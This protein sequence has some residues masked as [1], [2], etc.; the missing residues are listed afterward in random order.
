VDVLEPLSEEELA[1]LGRRNPD[2]RLQ[3]G[4]VFSTPGEH[5][6]KFFILKE[7]KVR[8]FR[9]DPEGHQQTLAQIGDGTPLSGQRLRGSYAEAVEPSVLM[10]LRFEDVQ[11][12]NE[13]NPEV[14]MRLIRLLVERLGRC[15]EK[16]TNVALKAVPAR[17]ASLILDLVEDEGVVTPEGF[18]I[19]AY[20]THEQLGMMI[21]ARR[22]AVSRAFS[23]LREAGAIETKPRRIHVKDK[24]ALERI[25]REERG[26]AGRTS[27]S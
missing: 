18:R 20:Y 25:A 15:D 27:A 7:G 1:E 26:R 10:S 2:I 24:E 8:I 12:L 19:P 22:V 13:R 3:A 21:G 17:L 4:E 14:G 23:K 5:D 9:Q 16:L 6:E 11:R